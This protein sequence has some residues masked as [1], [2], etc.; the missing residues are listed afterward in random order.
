MIK[1][2]EWKEEKEKWLQQGD[3]VH[4]IKFEDFYI[5]TEYATEDNEM[6]LKKAYILGNKIIDLSDF[7]ILE[8]TFQSM[9]TDIYI[10]SHN[11][12]N[13]I[14]EYKTDMIYLISIMTIESLQRFKYT[15]NLNLLTF[16]FEKESTALLFL[17]TLEDI[18]I[19]FWTQNF[20]K[21]DKGDKDVSGN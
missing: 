14:Y 21:K 12:N 1:K 4:I 7:N 5:R 19:K 20:I 3:G 10:K 11:I 13:D 6:I 18:R 8:L 15:E 2:I 17:S 16:A 9:P